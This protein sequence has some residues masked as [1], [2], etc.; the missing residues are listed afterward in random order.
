MAIVVF[1]KNGFN[2]SVENIIFFNLK[3]IKI[4]LILY[5]KGKIYFLTK[6]L[7]SFLKFALT[8]QRYISRIKN[9]K[10]G[11]IVHLMHL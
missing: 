8:S 6:S 4:S 5:N 9:Y 7:L 1:F 3:L 11:Q 2:R 10:K